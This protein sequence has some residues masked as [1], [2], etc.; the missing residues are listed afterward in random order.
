[1]ELADLNDRDFRGS[2]LYRRE[3]YSDTTKHHRFSLRALE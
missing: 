1:M 3:E 2:S